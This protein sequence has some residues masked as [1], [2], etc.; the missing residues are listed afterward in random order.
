MADAS[1]QIDIMR[2]VTQGFAAVMQNMGLQ[3]QEIEKL[4]N[5][6][7]LLKNNHRA[8]SQANYKAHDADG[9]ASMAYELYQQCR[10]QKQVADDLGITQG[11]VSQ[12]INQHKVPKSRI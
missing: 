7:E 11:R 9:K 12:L 5:D 10:N 8:Q 4:K 1:T 2:V 6:V 3:Q